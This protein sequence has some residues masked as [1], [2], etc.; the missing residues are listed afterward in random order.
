[1]A[2]TEGLVIG[3]AMIA[4]IGPVF[5]YLLKTTLQSGYKSGFSVACG[6]I[7]SD[8][9]CV[10]LCL[11]GF[12]PFFNNPANK[13][14]ITITGGIILLLLGTKY[15]FKPSISY[16]S[17]GT[18]KTK[19]IAGYF[20]KGFLINFVNPFVFL[21]WIGIIGLG[22]SKFG[23]TTKLYIFLSGVLAGIF[24]TDSLK[25]ILAQK[26]KPF[27]NPERLIFIYRI[28]GVVLIIFG[29]RVF[30]LLFI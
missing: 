7:T 15:L 2:F 8:I 1:M 20:T 10:I 23:N 19:Q 18:T 9:L 22:E 4:F 12:I 21:V 11:I 26:I 25:V 3:F 27:I 30:W 16:D 24:I 6:I 13:T 29:I 14:V 17:I 5:F 28:I